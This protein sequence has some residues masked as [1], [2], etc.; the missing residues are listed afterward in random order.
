MGVGG[1]QEPPAV[2]GVDAHAV[3]VGHGCA[4]FAQAGGHFLDDF[5]FTVVV[6]VEAEF[7]GVD[8][9]GQGLADGGE[10]FAAAGEDAEEA[11]GGVKCVVEA[12]PVV[13]EEDV[14]A[15]FAGERAVG[16]GHAGFYQRV[17]GFPHFGLAAGA[18]DFV[19][20]DLAGLDVGDDLRAGVVLQHVAGEDNQELVAEHHGAAVIDH[21][22]AV[23]V[24]VEGDAEVGFLFRDFRD[25]GFEVFRDGGVGVM[26]GEFAV[27]F[28]KQ[29]GV[30]SRQVF[31]QAHQHVAG[32][33]V[34]VVPDDVEGASA[35]VPILG[36][37]G[38]VLF[39]D[40][41]ASVAAARLGHHVA[42]G[43]HGADLLDLGAEKGFSGEHHLEAVVVR[44][45][46]AAGQHDGAAGLEH[47]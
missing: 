45:V 42:G 6:A 8:D 26:V 38:D 29:D 40:V 18:G 9:L 13:V 19:E 3:D 31:D 11:D 25:E 24:A 41:D 23:G 37:A 1:A 20:Q 35:A 12:V 14:A 33:A 39:G 15:H 4:G 10:F 30:G 16:F 17:A 22:D 5:E 28:G 27:D 32:G 7:G 47:R 46:V 44:R 2:G 43:G 36:E 21:A 34:A